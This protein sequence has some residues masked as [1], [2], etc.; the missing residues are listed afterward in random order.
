MT[1]T[2]YKKMIQR[3]LSKLNQR[4]DMKILQ[5]QSY[6]EEMR[7]HKV[8]LAQMRERPSQGG[9]LQRLFSLAV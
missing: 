2:Q 9:L 7:R 6:R 3:E 8:L 4:I 1:Q 5:G